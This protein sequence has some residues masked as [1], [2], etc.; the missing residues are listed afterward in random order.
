MDIH[1][2]TLAE[3]WV[4]GFGLRLTGGEHGVV[5]QAASH[6]LS[7]QMTGPASVWSSVCHPSP[8]AAVKQVDLEVQIVH[9]TATKYSPAHAF[10]QAS[11]RPY[12]NSAPE[13]AITATALFR[14]FAVVA[15]VSTKPHIPYPRDGAGPHLP[16]A[17]SQGHLVLCRHPAAAITRLHLSRTS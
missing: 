14:L 11:G 17:S 7:L 10:Q 12:R 3:W 9:Q 13:G 8:D 4:H 1:D 2:P 15:L 16:P 5:M 6:R